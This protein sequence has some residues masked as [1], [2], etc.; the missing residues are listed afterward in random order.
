M[1]KSTGTSFERIA[2]KVQ[3]VWLPILVYKTWNTEV[4]C[5]R[6]AQWLLMAPLSGQCWG[7]CH[8]TLLYDLSTDSPYV[9]HQCSNGC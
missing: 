4:D 8:I 2:L 6:V 3:I 7:I 5:V 1:L 9:V